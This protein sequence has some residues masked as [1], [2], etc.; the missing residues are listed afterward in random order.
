MRNLAPRREMI[1]A[2]VPFHPEEVQGTIGTYMAGGGA[3]EDRP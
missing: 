1:W 3:E 2:V